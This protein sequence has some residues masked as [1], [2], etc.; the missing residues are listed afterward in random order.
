VVFYYRAVIY[1][2]IRSSVQGILVFIRCY[3][4]GDF[5]FKDLNEFQ[6]KYCVV[7]MNKLFEEEKRNN[8]H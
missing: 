2:V 3:G 1:D 7:K 5:K 4:I 8:C 6:W